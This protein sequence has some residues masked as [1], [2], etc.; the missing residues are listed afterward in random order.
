MKLRYISEVRNFAVDESSGGGSG[1]SKKIDKLSANY[2]LLAVGIPASI[3]LTSK[4]Y[5]IVSDYRLN[6]YKDALLLRRNSLLNGYIDNHVQKGISAEI[7]PKA[8]DK[9]QKALHE[10][11]SMSLELHRMDSSNVKKTGRKTVNN[12]YIVPLL[13]LL[14]LIIIKD[15]HIL[16]ASELGSDRR[17]FELVLDPV[18]INPQDVAR[19]PH[20]T[21]LFRHRW[22]AHNF[23]VST[24]NVDEEA[25][26]FI[27]SVIRFLSKNPK[28]LSIRV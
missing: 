14:R 4:L 7:G 11:Y 8:E 19:D 23:D 28:L 10:L 24:G 2:L 26:Q 22:P 25:N 1:G 15:V 27:D 3:A 9:Y 20:R 13:S 16:P 17:D 6:K 5:K 18:N 21:I 12:M